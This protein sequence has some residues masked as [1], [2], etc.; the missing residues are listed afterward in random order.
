MEISDLIGKSGLQIDTRV[1]TT[2]M[3]VF[4]A[5]GPYELPNWPAAN[6]PIG[7]DSELPSQ[8]P[9]GQQASRTLRPRDVDD[10]LNR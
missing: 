9:T 4:A 1:A 8:Q 6:A 7:Q 2:H 10:L 5:R 3:R